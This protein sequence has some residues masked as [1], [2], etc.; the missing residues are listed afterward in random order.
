[1]LEG[2]ISEG[3]GDEQQQKNWENLHF[4]TP[5]RLFGSV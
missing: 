5:L 4:L 3:T 1:M 2:G